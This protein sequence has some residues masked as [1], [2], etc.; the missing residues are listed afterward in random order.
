MSDAA[1]PTP[2]PQGGPR[3]DHDNRA[4]GPHQIHWQADL[5]LVVAAFF[6]GTTFL[7]VK[8]AVEDAEPV[9]FLAVRFL[10]A[11]A[12]LGVAA[13][14]RP[15]SPKLVRHG[16]VAGLALGAGYVLQ[17]IGLQYTT[18][19]TSAF[20]TYVLVVF[21][22]ILTFAVTR[23]PPHPATL[24]AIGLALAGV[25]LL[26]GGGAAGLGRGE[27]LTLGCALGFAVHM[28][29][30]GSTAGRHDAVRFTFVQMATVG[31]SCLVIGV[32]TDGWSELALG[33]RALGAA[34]F[35]GLFATAVAF[36]AM[37]WAQ[38]AVSPPRAALI[39]LLEPV[40]AAALGAAAGDPV[41]AASVAGG[42]LILVAVIVSEVV[43]KFSARRL[44]DGSRSVRL[45]ADPSR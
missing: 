39:L 7:I 14:R 34:V 33:G 15:A 25:W 31:G 4:D 44:T 19:S 24:V 2:G 40:F 22:P 12:V 35:T 38:R 13:R 18:S 5:A 9:A 23:R 3:D 1:L 27:L 17:T 30:L 20:L 43:P 21:V 6:F 32:A 16:L 45:G 8:D 36:L 10:I 29:I 41:T 37:V 26:T 11:A 42:A 28:V